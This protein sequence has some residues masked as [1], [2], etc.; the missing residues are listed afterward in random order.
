MVFK[1][2]ICSN[3]NINIPKKCRQALS[4]NE[5]EIK[6]VEMEV[7]EGVVKQCVVLEPVR[8]D[9]KVIVTYE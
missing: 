9:K 4:S 7:S 5:V 2:K 8:V 3:G 6:V 1:K